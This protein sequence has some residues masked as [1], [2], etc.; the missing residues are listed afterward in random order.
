MASIVRGLRR[1][2]RTV[3]PYLDRALSR[4]LAERIVDGFT[5][6]HLAP[7]SIGHVDMHVARFL[8]ELFSVSVA[9]YRLGRSTLLVVEEAHNLAPAGED[10]ASKRA[11]L[12]I[13]REGRKWG[14]SLLLVSQRPGFIDS[15][16]LSQ[17][18]S[19]AAM[20]ITNPDDI[21]GLR[22][23]VESVSQELVD[24]LP[25]LDR[26]Q[27]VVSG[28]VVA[29]RKIPLL[30]MVEKLEPKRQKQRGQ[31]VQPR[32]GGGESVAEKR[33]VARAELR[34]KD[35]MAILSGGGKIDKR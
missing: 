23:S 35:L 9:K 21:A 16:I 17:A 3:S 34:P 27:A 15:N 8:E 2:K 29:E 13:A 5:I 24:H 7:P 20:R 32:R 19:I 25:D 11:L 1:V 6:I 10:R 12:R 18:A 26:G 33:E 22:R 4:R 14:L 31:E 30:V 28:M